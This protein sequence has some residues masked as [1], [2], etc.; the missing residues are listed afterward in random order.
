MLFGDENHHPQADA[1]EEQRRDGIAP[2]A[3]GPREVG[4][5]NSQDDE[6]YDGG[7]RTELDAELHA[8]E[9][10]FKAGGEQQRHDDGKLHKQSRH[11]HAAFIA[12]G[13]RGEQLEVLAHRFH[14]ARPH[15][16]HRRDARYQPEADQRGHKSRGWREEASLQ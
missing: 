5:P 14:H 2:A 16:G 1:E 9:H 12:D 13:Q 8:G 15:P 6:A 3:I 10:R 7:E 4:L 11:R